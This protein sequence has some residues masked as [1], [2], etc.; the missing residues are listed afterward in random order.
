MPLSTLLTGAHS[1]SCLFRCANLP[2]SISSVWIWSKLHSLSV[3]SQRSYIKSI[4]QLLLIRSNIKP[5]LPSIGYLR[6]LNGTSVKHAHNSLSS[7][8]LSKSCLSQTIGSIKQTTLIIG[9]IHHSIWDIVDESVHKQNN[10]TERTKPSSVTQTF[11]SILL[12]A[13]PLSLLH[14]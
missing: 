10:Y 7:T 6:G 9:V 3:A 11:T 12:P 14:E 13:L 2:P 1:N 5:V 4:N 8:L